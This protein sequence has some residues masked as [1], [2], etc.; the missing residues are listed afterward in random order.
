M[1]TIVSLLA[2]AGNETTARLIG[3]TGKVLAEH[4]DQRRQI[5][6]N[7]ALVPQAIE[8][9]LRFE[10]STLYIGRYVAQDAEFQ[11]VKVPK[12]SALLSLAPAANRDERKFKNGEQFDINRERTGHVTFGYGVHACLGNMLARMEGRIALDEVLNRFPEWEVDLENAEFTSTPAVRGWE[13]MPAYTPKSKR[14]K[15][16]PRN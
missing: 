6:E 4:P 13:S 1:R 7:R 8:E 3:W 2:A 5:Y 11:G 12:G 14:G 16:A 9:L 15:S 10:P